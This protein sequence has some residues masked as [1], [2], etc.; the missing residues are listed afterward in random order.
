MGGARFP[1]SLVG[2]PVVAG[3]TDPNSFFGLVP[4]LWRDLQT[5]SPFLFL[6]FSS[7]GTPVVAG[8]TD[9]NEN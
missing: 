5:Q 3:F 8:F 2:T 7:V 9:P 6:F 1:V 4:R